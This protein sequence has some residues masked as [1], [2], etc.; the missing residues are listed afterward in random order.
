MG[1][2]NNENKDFFKWGLGQ[3]DVLYISAI[4]SAVSS[5][6]STIALDFKN[7]AMTLLTSLFEQT[8]KREAKDDNSNK[9]IG[10]SEA[11]KLMEQGKI[12]KGDFGNGCSYLYKIEDGQILSVRDNTWVQSWITLQDALNAFWSLELQ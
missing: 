10:F 8:H 11:L 2:L 4:L 7:E 12:C 1:K 6:K 9:I 5:E 3:A